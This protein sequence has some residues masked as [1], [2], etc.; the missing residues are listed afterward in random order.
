MSA[1]RIKQGLFALGLACACSSVK[2]ARY[3]GWDPMPEGIP[4]AP[5]GET[6]LT[7]LAQSRRLWQAFRAH[8][9]RDARDVGWMPAREG[10]AYSYIR[11]EELASDRVAFTLLVVD[12]ERVTLRALVEADPALLEQ[13]AFRGEGNAVLSRWV[14]RGAQVG[15][16]P[17]GAPAFSIERLYDEC[18]RLISEHPASPPRLYFHPNG[19]L[20][21]CGLDPEACE[22]CPRLSV[23]SFSPY[24]MDEDV[25]A[26]EPARWI[27]TRG[28]G[29]FPPGASTPAYGDVQGCFASAACRAGNCP[30]ALWTQVRA[31]GCDG[32]PEHAP[33]TLELGKVDP[34]AAWVFPVVTRNG[35]ECG[36]PKGA[37]T[38]KPVLPEAHPAR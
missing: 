35:V 23:Q 29:A 6:A 9:T 21:H 20:M 33:R 2:H 5:N 11:A 12:G 16:H 14:E 31:P 28:V 8:R 24:R 18:A 13:D 17:D 3:A 19:V 22:D 1:G 25:P 15:G 36:A 7:R 26:G 10:D 30:R 4:V 37:W 32:S 38:I 27:C 34:L